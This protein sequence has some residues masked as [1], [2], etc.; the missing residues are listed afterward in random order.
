MRILIDECVDPR[1]KGLFS[2]HDAVTVREQGWATLAD[3]PLLI[4]LGADCRSRP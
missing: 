1:F 4:A 3:G 2:G